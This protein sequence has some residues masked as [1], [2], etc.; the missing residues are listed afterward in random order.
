MLWKRALEKG[1]TEKLMQRILRVMESW[2]VFLVVGG[3]LLSALNPSKL[4]KTG[5]S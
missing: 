5:L 4:G 1:E 2:C 3:R